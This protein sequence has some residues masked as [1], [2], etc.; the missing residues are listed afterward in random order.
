MCVLQR[1]DPVF[2][3]F[4]FSPGRKERVKAMEGDY[5]Y[6]TKQCTHTIECTIEENS[7]DTWQVCTSTVYIGV[8]L[9]SS[10][11]LAPLRA[12]GY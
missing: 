5:G 12:T 9:I 1:F 3:F 4:F 8:T 2:F 6:K 7:C 10:A 11:S